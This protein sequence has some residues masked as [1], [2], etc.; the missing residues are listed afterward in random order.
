MLLG[1]LNSHAVEFFYRHLSTMLQGDFLRFFTQYVDQIPVP[2]ATADQRRAVQELVGNI[3]DAKGDES[4]T[5]QWEAELNEL[6][7]KLYG[8]TKDE[9]RIIERTLAE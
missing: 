5:M 7:Y 8:L 1:V 4:Q 6:V 2:A 3:L 9:I